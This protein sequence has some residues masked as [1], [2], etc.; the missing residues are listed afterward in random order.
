MYYYFRFSSAGCLSVEFVTHIKEVLD[1]F[2][3]DLLLLLLVLLVLLSILL[4]CVCVCVWFN[5]QSENESNIIRVVWYFVML[6]DG[7][8]SFQPQKVAL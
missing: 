5:L 8:V 7:L 6:Y 2:I 1:C 4:L 3:L